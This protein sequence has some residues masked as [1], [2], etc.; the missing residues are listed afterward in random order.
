MLATA[1]RGGL[2]STISN[3]VVADFNNTSWHTARTLTADDTKT[4]HLRASGEGRWFKVPVLASSRVD[5][6][7]TGLPS[8]Y[9]LI[10]FNDIQAAYD[11]ILGG[12]DPTVGP[13]LA[14][15]DLNRQAAETPTDAFNTS[16]Y[17]SSSWDPTN[18]EPELNTSMFSA[19]QWSAS[20]WSA[21][22]WSASQW[23]AS[24]WS[25]SQWSASQWSASQWSASQWS[26]SQWSAS[27]WSASQWSDSYPAHPKTFADAQTRSL[28]AVSAG[29]GTGDES[30]S[31]NT[32]NN[33]GH[34]YIRVQGKNGSF[35]AANPFTI[36]VSRTGNLCSG[37]VDQP[38]TAP[39]IA[40]GDTKSLILVDDSRLSF[41]ASLSA[42]L[43]EFRDRPEVNGEIVDVSSF[44]ALNTLNEQA[45]SPALRGCPYAKNL[46]AMG[47]KKLVDAYRKS[48]PIEYLVVIGDDDV[49]PFFRS[50]DPALMANETLYT[51]PVR[52]DTASQASLRLGYVLTDDFLAS[53]DSVSQHG[54]KFPVP[55]IAAGRLVETPGEIEGMLDA[56]LGTTNGVVATPTSSLVTGYDFL[57]DAADVIGEHLAEGVGPGTHTRLI[58]DQGVSPATTTVGTTPDRNHSWT[59]E[60]LRRALL[61]SGR[62]DMIFLSGHFSANDALGADY[63]TN[64]LSTELPAS[65]VDFTNTIVF[66]AGCHAG[67]NIVNDHATQWTEP[68]DW[69]QAFA[70]KRATLIA[71]TGY[72]YGETEFLA[73][74]ERIYAEFARQLRLTH[75]TGV[76]VPVDVGGALLRSKQD[77][78][79][80][81][82]GLTALDEKALL[83][84]TLF[85]FPMLSV[86]LPN[87]RFVDPPDASVVPETDPVDSGPGAGLGLRT[88]PVEF[89]SNLTPQELQLQLTS[90]GLPNGPLAT[91]LTG[92][93]GVAVRPTQ[94]ILPLQS[95]N[96]TLPGTEAPASLRGVGF[97]SGTYTDELGTTPLTAAPATELRGIHAPFFADVFFPTQT[98]TP[99]YF[100]ALGPGGGDTRLLVTPVQHRSESPTM[101]RR[102]FSDLDFQLFYSGNVASYCPGTTPLALAPCP[103]GPFGQPTFAATPALSAPPTISGVTTSFDEDTRILTFNARVVGDPVA[104]IQT[105]WVTW[106]IPPVAGLTGFWDSIDLTLDPDDS[107]LWTGQLVVP[108]GDDPGDVHFLVQAVSGVGRLTIDDNVGAFYRPGS[109]PGV[110]QTVPGA[111]DP[112]ATTMTITTPT[113]PPPASV[114]FGGSFQ[115]AVRLTS[116]GNP[117]A[118]KF[119]RIGLGSTG[120]PA[121]TDTDGRA[122]VELL[123]SLTPSTYPMTASFPGDA[124]HASSSATLPVTV[125]A[126]PTTLT[127]G[128]TVNTTANVG[129]ATVH[130]ILQATAPT[131]P[132]H[133]RSVF[134]IFRGTGPANVGH[135]NVFSGKTDPTGR[136]DVSSAFLSSLPVGDY[137]IDAYFNGVNVP[138]VLVLPPDSPGYQ[139]ATAHA[140]FGLR[141]PFSGFFSPVA[142]PPALN[143]VNPGSTIPVKFGLGGNRGLAIFAAGYPRVTPINCSTRAATGPSQP[144][145]PNRPLQYD[146]ILQRYTFEWKTPKSFANTCRQLTLRFVDGSS[147]RFAFFKFGK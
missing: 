130:A 47:I 133:Q 132:L 37:V 63:K 52:D 75:T 85:G 31:V 32:W 137:D 147:D 106:T 107:T 112:V 124:M 24:Q 61:Q 89:G 93:S 12:A 1:S 82:P 135:T 114:T 66:S 2:T 87:G 123:A 21:S 103:P 134:L 42:K 77:F 76:A 10:V 39:T 46:V 7:L 4:G 95:V 55:D 29:P 20:Q 58:T 54:N 6:R 36:Q 18:W 53:S 65:P 129:L 113:T 40:A 102:V 81:T 117:V 105:V 30:V 144:A 57:Q 41:N 9:D 97:R 34:F 104:G 72:Q 22:Q 142:N 78:L 92:P 59:G 110:G 91:Y 17:N 8:D 90:D 146:P 11:E 119:V 121:R 38:F 141:W 128:G 100:D 118:N 140:T 28:L 136:V 5:V 79:K 80:T 45:D 51:P 88:A 86:N 15:T 127:L 145:T 71:G 49:I 94:P 73:H 60:D 116:G 67:Y 27:Q 74:S 138:G 109:I 98:W 25:A 35:D 62:H 69:V 131:T 44:P 111:P 14:I 84:T 126:R 120:L 33:T 13:N 3:C 64:V 83:Q 68:V 23:S 56:Y 99:N 108:E 43:N 70:Q 96:V 16:Q 26:A 125:T 101:T 48:N 19:S 139:P 122:T 50:P 143:Q 115:V